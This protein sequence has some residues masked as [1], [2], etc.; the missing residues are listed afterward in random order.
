M[1]PLLTLFLL[2]NRGCCSNRGFCQQKVA[3]GRVFG[4]EGGQRVKLKTQCIE[5]PS[6]FLSGF[7]LS[8]EMQPD[9]RPVY[10]KT[11]HS[12]SHFSTD[13]TECFLCNT[14]TALRG[15]GDGL[16]GHAFLG[17]RVRRGQK[18]NKYINKII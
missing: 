9:V 3:L 2:G 4:A 1:Y 12:F 13:M 6:Q 14:H 15:T 7:P 16:L 18:I 10:P 11:T 8:S 17:Q 5:L